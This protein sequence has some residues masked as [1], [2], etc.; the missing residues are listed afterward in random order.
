MRFLRQAFP[1]IFVEHD[2]EDLA[3]LWA[4]VEDLT[5]RGFEL[6]VYA[7]QFAH[8]VDQLGQSRANRRW[9][10]FPARRHPTDAVQSVLRVRDFLLSAIAL[11]L[12]WPLLL[13]V[14]LIVKVSSPGPV[15]FSTDV[16][17]KNRRHFRWYK[18][19]SM[20][21]LPGA[22]D[23]EQR[24]SRFQSYVE[25]TAES[26]SPEVPRKVIDR[27]RLTAAGQVLR[28]YSID[29]LPQLWNVLRGEMALVGPRP[30]LPYEAAF[31]S[32]W[33]QR[34][35]EVLPGLTGVWQVFGRG[36]VG[37]EQAAAMDV[38]YVYRRTFLFDLSLIFRT[39]K[40]V[41]AGKGAL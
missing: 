25:G 6:W 20:R 4:R 28:K 9:L 32:G 10:V 2:S 35:F 12:L 38:F 40:V 23:V 33:Q 3:T 22:Q 27:Q 30:C 13:L 31:Y 29:E 34:R 26:P 14:A 17:G 24:R 21:V 5:S 16:V 8:L 18:F 15:L 41:L 7:P 11:L 36:R 1:R 37:F 39:V 19:R